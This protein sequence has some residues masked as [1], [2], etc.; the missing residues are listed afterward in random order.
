MDHRKY[1]RVIYQNGIWDFQSFSQSETQKLSSS[2]PLFC[3]EQNSAATLIV[4][5]P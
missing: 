2:Q 4:K 5:I 3:P 1:E